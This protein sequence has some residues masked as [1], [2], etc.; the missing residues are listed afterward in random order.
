MESGADAGQVDSGA[1]TRTEG[2][3]S[4]ITVKAKGDANRQRPGVGTLQFV[5]GMSQQDLAAVIQR[6]YPQLGSA[7]ASGAR[8]SA[9]SAPEVTDHS[10][11]A[12]AANDER[13]ASRWRA[14]HERT[15]RH[16]QSVDWPYFKDLHST[17][18]L[19]KKAL[20]PP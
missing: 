10:R 3:P 4:A 18:Q 1:T 19:F 12:G 7:G 16:H 6:N 5:D 13:S 8:A 15:G 11:L 9:A 2:N 20:G 14:V 17:T